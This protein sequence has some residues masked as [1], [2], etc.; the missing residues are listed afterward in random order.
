MPKHPIQGIAG[1]KPQAK[2]GDDPQAAARERFEENTRLD[3]IYKEKRNAILDIKHKREAMELAI[4]REKLINKDLVIR[5]MQ[6]LVIGMRQKLLH[7]P[8]RIGGRLHG[9]G[10]LSE[11][12]VRTAANVS[13]EV[14]HEVLCEMADLPLKVTDPNWMQRLQELEDEAE[15]D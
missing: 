2:T 5:Q 3:R 6:F 4:Q 13:T 12:G 10:G 7:L 15:E 8:S 9:V 14:V 1:S 11:A